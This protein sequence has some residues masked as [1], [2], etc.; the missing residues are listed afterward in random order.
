MHAN[1]PLHSVQAAPCMPQVVFTLPSLQM[2]FWQQPA[3]VSGPQGSPQLPP[4]QESPALQLWQLAPPVPHANVVLPGWQTPFTQHPEHAPHAEPASLGEPPSSG[5]ASVLE[6][7]RST[8]MPP[9]SVIPASTSF[10]VER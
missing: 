9:S 3:Q 5:A 1:P 4:A 8:R 2:P 6:S 7:A 10:G